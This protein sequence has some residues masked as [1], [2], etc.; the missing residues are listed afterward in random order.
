MLTVGEIRVAD[1]NFEIRTPSVDPPPD[2]GAGAVGADGHT[3][4]YGGVPG[5]RSRTR[6]A[7]EGRS[8][9]FR[10]ARLALGQYGASHPANVGRATGREPWALKIWYTRRQC[11]HGWTTWR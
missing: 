8:T 9:S 3:L 1:G 11:E 7:D 10:V 6:V 2:L 4:P 5:D